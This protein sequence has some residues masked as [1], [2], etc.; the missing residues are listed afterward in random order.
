VSV[1]IVALLSRVNDTITT[2]RQPTVGTA[3]TRDVF[4]SST[5]IAL[6]SEVDD[7]ITTSSWCAVKTA[8]ARVS[9]RERGV[10]VSGSL[11]TL[12]IDTGDNAR[13]SPLKSSV[14]AFAV[15]EL[16]EIVDD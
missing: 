5:K 15:R 2:S 4:V 9:G 1:S 10:A 13:V 12:F 3:N 7:T 6:F 16:R 11:V 14:A 8:A